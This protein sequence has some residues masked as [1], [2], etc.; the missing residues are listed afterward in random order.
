MPYKTCA[1]SYSINLRVG[2]GFWISFVN[3]CVSTTV[4]RLFGM[5]VEAYLDGLLEFRFL[6]WMYPMR[7]GDD[8]QYD[9]WCDIETIWPWKWSTFL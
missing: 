1:T 9:G 5:P 3:A 2:N 7:S 8:S 6:F 4:T